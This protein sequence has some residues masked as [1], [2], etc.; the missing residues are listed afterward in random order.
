VWKNYADVVNE[1]NEEE[2]DE[3]IAL[4]GVIFIEQN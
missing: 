4:F 3:T 2:S 1:E